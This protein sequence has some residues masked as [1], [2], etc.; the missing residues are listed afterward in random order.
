M[1][2]PQYWNKGYGTNL[3]NLLLQKANE[4]H[5]EA[6]IIA[7]TNPTNTYSKRILQRAGFELVKQYVNEDN[8]PA[9]LYIK[10]ANRKT[11]SIE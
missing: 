7:I 10:K 3:V 8:E 4:T 11:A 5:K 1:L 6:A 9:E 2:L